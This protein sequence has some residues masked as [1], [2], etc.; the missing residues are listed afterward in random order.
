MVDSKLQNGLSSMIKNQRHM[1]GM[2]LLPLLNIDEILKFSQLNRASYH[3]LLKYVNFKV[4]FE[5]W[6]I[7]LTDAQ[8]EHTKISLASA[9]KVALKLFM[10]KSIIESQQMIGK[11]S[12]VTDHVSLPDLK[13][14]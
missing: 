4:L 5:A 13:T 6:G 14:F 12:V 9:L 2:E 1:T 11:Y 3:L 10:L 7:H 8:V